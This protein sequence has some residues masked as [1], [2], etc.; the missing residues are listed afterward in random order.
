MVVMSIRIERL[1]SHGLELRVTLQEGRASSPG[2]MASG[3]ADVQLHLPEHE[4]L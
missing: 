3:V 4:Q 1:D 2:A